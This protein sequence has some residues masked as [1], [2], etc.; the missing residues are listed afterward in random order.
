MLSLK[1]LCQIAFKKLKQ[2]K[3]KSVS[4]TNKTSNNKQIIKK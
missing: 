3:D 4:S 1:Q 2:L